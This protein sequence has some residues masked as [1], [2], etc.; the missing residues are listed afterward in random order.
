MNKILIKRSNQYLKLLCQRI[1]DRSVGSAGNRQA[2]DYV[3]GIFKEYGWQTES[4]EF[5]VMDWQ[6]NGA[7]LICNDTPFEV[8]PSPYS[9]GCNVEG[10]LVTAGTLQEL[11]KTD[12]TGAILLV[13]GE[14]VTEQLMPKNFV[15]YN[16]ENH[17]HLVYLLEN[18]GAQA[19]ISATGR[20]ASMAG[21]VYPFPF[22]EDGDF[23]IPN[24][25]TTEEE[26][27][28]LLACAGQRV[29]LTSNAKR[30][31]AK[32][33]NAIGKI[34]ESTNKKIVITAH[35]DA[36]KG[37]PGAIDN[38][39]GITVLLLLAELLKEYNGSYQVELVA[40]NGEDHYAVPGQMNYINSKKGDFSDIALNINIDGAAYREGPS[41]FSFYQLPEATKTKMQGII[42][43]T[44]N[45]VEGTPWVQG[46]H[47]IFVQFGC[48]AMA[49][50]SEWFIDNIET[51][52]IT[53][54]EKDNLSIVNAEK[55]VQ[56]AESITELINQLQ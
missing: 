10:R 56:I 5:D 37:S 9:K 1:F 36:K 6:Q 21:G 43:N 14:I 13:H 52:T 35:I 8:K 28:R 44:P 17:K 48:P 49:V 30:V 42:K 54:T 53:H 4:P 16:P 15:F 3:A 26:G 45:I 32:A 7:E 51:Q 19:I 18:S 38:G 39:T 31:P 2:T 40:F 24:V 34:G 23:D 22:I 12:A 29:K 27:T 41:A 50:S 11:E 55:V 20:N 47:S 33:C 46:D 25:F